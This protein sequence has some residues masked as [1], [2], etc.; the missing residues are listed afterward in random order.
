MKTHLL[1]AS[2]LLA[3][4]HPARLNASAAAATTQPEPGLVIPPAR[5]A[6][7]ENWRFGLFIH[8]GP[9]SQTGEGAI[10]KITRDMTPDEQAKAFELRRTFNPRKF[11]P[12]RW[13]RAAHEAG[14]KYVVF[15]T[16]HHDGFCMWDTQLTDMKITDASCPYSK[17]PQPDLTRAVVD[18]FRAEGL[19]IGFYYSHIDWHHPDGRYFSISHPDYDPARVDTDPASWRRFADYE[20]GQVRELLSQYGKIDLLWYDIQWAHAGGRHV[21]PDHPVVAADVRRLVQ[22]MHAWQPD[23][24]YDDRGLG[25][26][27]G[28]HTPEQV[29]PETGLPGAWE[30]SITINNGG[31]YWYKG[32]HNSA[33]T[34]ADVIRTLAEIA[35]KG[36]NLLLN[37]GPSPEGELTAADYAALEGTGRWLKTNG[38][39]IYGT[40]RSRWKNLPWGWSTTGGSTLYLLV[41]DWPADGRLRVPGLHGGI[42]RAWRLADPACTPLAVS[43]QGD[44]RSVALGSKPADLEPVTVVAIEMRDKFQVDNFIM[45]RPDGGID[46]PA[47]SAAISGPHAVYDQGFDIYAANYAKNLLGPA[48]RLTWRFDA[49]PGRYAYGPTTPR[50]VRPWAARSASANGAPSTLTPPPP[51]PGRATFSSSGRR[52]KKTRTPTTP[53]FLNACCSDRSR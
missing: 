20:I 22:E 44:Y 30:S 14:M 11:D 40:E 6:Q 38:A 52:G 53:G 25:I 27:G 39:A 28:F 2:L 36:G 45:P 35:A 8:W 51:R 19:A 31:G 24:I 33:K 49:R 17:A 15:T 46:L 5:L 23:L 48:D 43:D 32:P 9:W 18:A 47:G 12:A 21:L 29:I 16:K 1:L 26:Y 7:F 3:G 34:A 37:V 10:W 41:R 4:S 13:A 42:A 50:A